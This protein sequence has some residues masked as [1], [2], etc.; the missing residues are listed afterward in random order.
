MNQKSGQLQRL[1]V[2]LVSMMIPSAFAIAGCIPAIARTFDQIPLS[3]VEL[4]A[5]IPSLSTILTV[6][7]SNRIAMVIGTKTTISLGLFIALISGV[8]PCFVTSFPVVLLSRVLLGVGIGLFNSL[9]IQMIAELYTGYLR[10]RMLGIES[11]LEGTSGVLMTVAVGQLQRIDWQI[12][13]GVYALAL[14][15]LILFMVFVP[16]TTNRKKVQDADKVLIEA[17]MKEYREIS[18]VKIAGYFF[19]QLVVVTCFMSFNIKISELITSLHYGTP[20]DG[21]NLIAV[22]SVGAISAGFFFGNVYRFTGRFTVFVSVSLLTLAALG[23][24]VSN[25]LW[26]TGFGSLL[27]GL[28]FRTFM[29]YMY[30]MVSAFTPAKAKFSTSLILAGYN[31]GA[32]LCPYTVQVIQKLPFASSLRGL[33]FVEASI[34]FFIVIGSLLAAL[35]VPQ[36]AA[37]HES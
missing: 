16:N 23:F 20:T 14:P 37:L 35:F 3:S 7:L 27:F 24:A 28:G 10:S 1:S 25:N 22:L 2:L 33:F 6:M 31:L 34:L 8:A 29:P 5:T 26:L 18:Y 4:L 17:S 36:R 12:A 19:L 13:F 9:I 32:T 15:I 30:Q 21:S 11:A